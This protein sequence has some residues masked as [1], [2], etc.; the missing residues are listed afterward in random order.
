MSRGGDELDLATAETM[1]L[2]AGDGH[3]ALHALVGEWEGVTYTW[4]DPDKPP[5]ASGI[6]M[7]IQAILGGRFVRLEY[8]GQVMGKGHAGEML[9]GYDLSER[10]FTAAWVDSFHMA[11]GI[12]MSAGER[13]D[14]GAIAV[15]GSYDAAGQKWG[16]RTVL[17]RAGDGEGD[18]DALL[19]EATNISPDGEEHR[20]IASRLTR[21]ATPA[22]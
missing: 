7:R 4:L 12:M 17:R 15:L 16:W 19:V 6:E 10:R 22:P 1:P 9:V 2:S 14:D 20:A 8:R 18:G 3:R 5:D 11:S 21:R 13:R